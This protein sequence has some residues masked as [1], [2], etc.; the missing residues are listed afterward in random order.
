M[1][2]S[3]HKKWVIVED[4]EQLETGECFVTKFG[5]CMVNEI[6]FRFGY[7]CEVLEPYDEEYVEG[8][9][10]RLK[11]GDKITYDE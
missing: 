7:W 1:A 10:F 8:Q 11:I 2:T 9:M 4:L 5:F 3:Y 6:D